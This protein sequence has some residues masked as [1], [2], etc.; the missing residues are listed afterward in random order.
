MAFDIDM[1]KGVYSQMAERVDQARE[2]VGRPLTLSEKILYSPLWVGT[3]T[4]AVSRG[5]DY[6]DFDPVRI[7]SQN[8]TAQMALLQFM[9]SG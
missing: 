6:V 2:L 3:P 5:K 1:I 7:D 4:K 8:A 9:Q